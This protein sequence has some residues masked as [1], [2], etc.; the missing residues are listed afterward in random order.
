MGKLLYF[1]SISPLRLLLGIMW[2]YERSSLQK[3]NCILF[4]ML[5]SLF[6]S[7]LNVH[8]L[9]FCGCVPFQSRIV[10]VNFF[11]EGSLCLFW[12]TICWMGNAILACLHLHVFRVS[13]YMLPVGVLE[14]TTLTCGSVLDVTSLLPPFSSRS[15]WSWSYSFLPFSHRPQYCTLGQAV[16]LI[17]STGKKKSF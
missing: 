3:R 1:F 12:R 17:N 11:P 15:C 10:L 9:H 2:D 14:G 6:P 16:K 8:Q 5:K 4:S 13:D 7:V